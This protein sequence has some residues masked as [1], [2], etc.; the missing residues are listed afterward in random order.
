MGKGTRIEREFVNLL[1][2]LGFEIMRAPASGA[3]T[4]RDLPDVL[5]GNG[6]GVIVATEVKGWKDGTHYFDEAEVAA[7]G[8]FARGFHPA[9]VPLLVTR[10]NQD[11]NFY[12]R[13][14]GD[15]RLHT[16]DAGNVRAKKETCTEEW[17]TVEGFLAL[18]E[19][20]RTD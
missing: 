11:T 4:D 2:D 8:R 10:W 19:E 13:Q 5:A 6:E 20:V 7:L 15:A 3:A 9:C 12:V 14:V 17:R 16:T 18:G 1:R